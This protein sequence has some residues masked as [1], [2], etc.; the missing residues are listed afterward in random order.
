MGNCSER[1]T[2]HLDGVIAEGRLSWTRED[3]KI[4]EEMGVI[5]AVKKGAIKSLVAELKRFEQSGW[6]TQ[7][8][9]RMVA[10]S[11]LTGHTRLEW[12]GTQPGNNANRW[13][14]REQLETYL[15]LHDVNG[16]RFVAK[17]VGLKLRHGDPGLPRWAAVRDVNDDAPWQRAVSKLMRSVDDR[18]GFDQAIV[19]QSMKAAWGRQSKNK[20]PARLRTLLAKKRALSELSLN[21]VGAD[22]VLTVGAVPG[23][24]EAL[25]SNE[26]DLDEARR[27]NETTR[28]SCLELGL[29]C[30]VLF[31]RLAV[32]GK[33]MAYSQDKTTWGWADRKMVEIHFH[34]QYLD[35]RIS[36]LWNVVELAGSVFGEADAVLKEH[37]RLQQL[38]VLLGLVM[39]R[40]YHTS[41][42]MSDHAADTKLPAIAVDEKRRG[43]HDSLLEVAVQHAVDQHNKAEGELRELG[44]EVAEL[45]L[46]LKDLHARGEEALELE[47]KKIGE[48]EPTVLVNC[49][50]H[51]VTLMGNGGWTC[52]GKVLADWT[53][54]LKIAGYHE[55]NGKT[56]K[57]EN[58]PLNLVFNI[59]RRYGAFPFK[60]RFEGLRQSLQKEGVLTGVKHGKHYVYP[61]HLNS[62]EKLQ[63]CKASQTRDLTASMMVMRINHVDKTAL[64]GE[65]HHL[66]VIKLFHQMIVEYVTMH[67]KESLGRYDEII[68][69]QL[70]YPLLN[71]TF[72]VSDRY[73]RNV[74]M[75][76]WA[77]MHGDEKGQ[78]TNK[79]VQMVEWVKSV[80]TE[81]LSDETKLKNFMRGNVTLHDMY[82]EA[83]VGD[84]AGARAVAA[85][86]RAVTAAATAPP[87]AAREAPEGAGNRDAP[88][89]APPPPALLAD[90]DVDDD[91]D[92]VDDVRDFNAFV[93]RNRAPAA[94]RQGGEGEHQQTERVEEEEGDQQVT[95]SEENLNKVETELER[96]CIEA[97]LKCLE[98]HGAARTLHDNELILEPNAWQREAYLALPSDARLDESTFASMGRDA[99]PS[100]QGDLALLSALQKIR[101]MHELFPDKCSIEWFEETYP[102]LNLQA[103][104][105]EQDDQRRRKVEISLEK[106][107]DFEVK[108]AEAVKKARIIQD[109]LEKMKDVVQVLVAAGRLTQAEGCVERNLTKGV[110]GDYLT[111]LEFG[112]PRVKWKM[113]SKK[114]A[115]IDEAFLQY[116]VEVGGRA[117]A[118]AIALQK[119][120]DD[121]RA[122]ADAEAATA[123]ATAAAAAAATA[124]DIPDPSTSAAAPDAA[125]ELGTMGRE[126]LGE[127]SVNAQV[128][129]QGESSRREG[130]EGDSPGDALREQVTGSSNAPAKRPRPA[131]DPVLKENV[132]RRMKLRKPPTIDQMKKALGQEN[133]PKGSNTRWADYA[134]A[135][136]NFQGELNNI[137]PQGN[138]AAGGNRMTLMEALK[139]S[140]QA[141]AGA[142]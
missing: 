120:A 80:L 130:V 99:G 138:N 37:E 52:M 33:H 91:D 60:G 123:A 134:H 28:R 43:E 36:Y 72:N 98:K 6:R 113:G 88:P 11:C 12:P 73:S 51:K 107:E 114:K 42:S 84:V 82:K 141:A 17:S 45:E 56:G 30:D 109:R 26:V 3:V 46:R 41:G 106:Y 68:R 48:F 121:A 70:E 79:F 105:R 7:D 111:G 8:N 65:K 40:W 4:D 77:M 27:L 20:V 110:M 61:K 23:A 97:G 49:G 128:Q 135:V 39:R 59:C 47:L 95:I 129:G 119:V 1:A 133:H 90:V 50:D 132:A 62:L 14:T 139:A 19:E 127:I 21:K 85:A 58:V 122:K 87:P 100:L 74:L 55:V 101:F 78:D 64:K 34:I 2:A 96:A 69:R 13:K 94:P 67:K 54:V 76:F 131:D 104:A 63:I 5:T 35:R 38:Q 9:L 116:V 86:A 93:E 102:N 108:H 75:S 81:L 44:L 140:E 125:T 126:P 25:K 29:V 103:M 117:C 71:L 66:E 24:L 31:A 112:N 89:R 83:G 137:A 115:E 22:L 32:D 124:T 142:P 53:D 57:Y 18:A 10:L 118:V 136:V 92:D 15:D 16:V